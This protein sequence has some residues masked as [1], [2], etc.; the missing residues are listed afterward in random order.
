MGVQM[1]LFLKTLGK[2]KIPKAVA[3]EKGWLAF[4]QALSQSL[5]LCGVKPT[6]DPAPQSLGS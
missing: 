4:N 6:Q 2:K 3:Q 1:D 5:P